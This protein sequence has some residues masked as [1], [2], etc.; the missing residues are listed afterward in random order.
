MIGIL[1]EIERQ[2]ALARG[3]WNLS[4]IL[5]VGIVAILFLIAVVVLRRW[6]R[7]QLKAI[8]E[9]RNARRAGQSIGRVDAW[10]AGSDRYIDHDKLLDDDA[11]KH[12]NNP[13]HERI[14]E[15][16]EVIPGHGV[17][18]ADQPSGSPASDEDD[19]DP[20]GLFLDKPYQDPDD[21]DEPFDDDGD[22]DDEDDDKE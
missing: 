12:E 4:F 21:E 19:P 15:D 18:Q 10:A 8:D 13:G 7:R 14:D 3:W 5:F 2:E 1:A 9:D 20:Y 11:F 16:D 17:D 22:W 6:K